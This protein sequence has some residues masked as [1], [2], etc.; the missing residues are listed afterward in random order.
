MSFANGFHVDPHFQSGFRDMLEGMEKICIEHW[1]P[2]ARRIEVDV[3]LVTTAY[4]QAAFARRVRVRID[5][6]QVWILSA[7]DLV[8]HKLVAG[9]A[10]DRADIQNILLIQGVPDSEYL[11]AW[12]KRLD[13]TDALRQ[14][15]AEAGL[16]G[17]E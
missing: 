8:L 11:H 17:A 1:T 15:I 16:R 5:S 14:A 12:D 4:Q 9:R 2:E 3:F 6:R 10:K 7:A 13:V